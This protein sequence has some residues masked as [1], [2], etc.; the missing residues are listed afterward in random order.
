MLKLLESAGRP[1]VEGGKFNIL[2]IP[3]FIFNFL[4]VKNGKLIMD[5]DSDSES[6]YAIPKLLDRGRYFFL[7][8]AVVIT[9][10]ITDSK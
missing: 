6:G 1:V 8:P 5:S 3:E 7:S 4:S 9:F 10:I 2:V